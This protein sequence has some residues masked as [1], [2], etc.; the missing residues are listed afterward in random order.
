MGEFNGFVKE[1]IKEFTMVVRDSN[2][3]YDRELDVD[4]MSLQ[5]WN[6]ARHLSD[7]LEENE[8]FIKN[9]KIIEIGSGVGL[10]SLTASKLGAEKVFCTEYTEIALKVIK[11]NIRLN[12]RSNCTAAHLDWDSPS[13]LPIYDADTVIA[14]D[15]LF[16]SAVSRK[17]VTLLN[18]IFPTSGQLLLVHELRYGVSMSGDVDVTDEPFEL[19]LSLLTSPTSL[20]K[21]RTHK[22]DRFVFVSATKTA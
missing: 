13:S 12:D 7:W 21:V 14:S 20:W 8:I 3:Q 15:I 10:A 16:L 5:I 2:A 1:N 9:K 22:T 18:S 4:G 17:V 19:F 11:E 6:S